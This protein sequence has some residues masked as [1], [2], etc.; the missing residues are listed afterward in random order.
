[1][2]APLPHFLRE[3]DWTFLHQQTTVFPTLSLPPLLFIS[4]FPSLSVSLS[5]THPHT[6]GGQGGDAVKA[7]TPVTD[8]PPSPTL[9]V[10]KGAGKVEGQADPITIV[11]P[12][13]AGGAAGGAEK[14]EGQAAPTVLKVSDGGLGGV[15]GGAGKDPFPVLPYTI[16]PT[17]N[18]KS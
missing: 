6:Q 8:A 13:A 9:V 7:A 14:V 18:P 4:P 3:S 5:Y 10:G 17:L 2:L 15:G 16:N 12:P 11:A 1:M